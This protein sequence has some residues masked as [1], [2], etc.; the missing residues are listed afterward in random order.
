MAK[1]VQMARMAKMAKIARIAKIA[2]VAEIAKIAETEIV[3]FLKL[4]EIRYFFSGKID[5]FFD[6]KFDFFSESLKVA[7]LL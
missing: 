4:F 1:V 2:V 3:R 5:D 6:K 7:D